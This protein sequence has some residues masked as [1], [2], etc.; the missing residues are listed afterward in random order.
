M[1]TVGLQQAVLSCKHT[2]CNYPN[3]KQN[4]R[5]KKAHESH[6]LISASCLWSE[7]S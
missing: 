4:Q 3:I 6:G 5:I 1:V 7:S 2:I